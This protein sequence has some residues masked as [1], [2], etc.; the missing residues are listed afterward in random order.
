MRR[1]YHNDDKVKKL[2]CEAIVDLAKIKQYRSRPFLSYAFP[3]G[4]S[5]VSYFTE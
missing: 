5:L 2:R 1:V 4:M 3:A